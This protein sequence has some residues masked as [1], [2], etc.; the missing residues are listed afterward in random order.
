MIIPIGH[1]GKQN[2]LSV[3]RNKTGFV[4]KYLDPVSFVPMLGGTG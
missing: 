2:L 3:V 1:S 4:E